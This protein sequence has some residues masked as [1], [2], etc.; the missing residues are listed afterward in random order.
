MSEILELMRRRK[1]WRVPFD[2]ARPVPPEDISAVLEAAR[3]TPSAHNMQ[4]WEIVVVDDPKVLDRLAAVERP[5]SEEFI[6]EN[7]EQLSFSKEELLQ[8]GTGLLASMFPA[9][10]VTPDF[11][12][13]ALGENGIASRQRALL[14]TAAMLVVLYDPSR[15][16]PASLGDF[17]G[18]ISLGCLMQNMWLAAEARGLAMQIVSSLGAVAEVKTILGIPG[19]LVIAFSC[20][21]GYPVAEPP[22]Y[23]R[24]RRDIED[25]THRNCYGG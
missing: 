23:L 10:W 21:L 2:S 1:S 5:I 9:A 8:R 25:F 11:K 3:W 19:H 20:R 16:A 7:Y 12:A 18:I 4:N 15:R 13:D 6:R 22:D 14:P 17:L 24:V